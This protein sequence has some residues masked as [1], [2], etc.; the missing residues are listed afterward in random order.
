VWH[1]LANLVCQV[2]VT[3]VNCI[4]QAFIWV[5][6]WVCLA[7]VW[8][9]KWVCMFYY[10]VFWLICINGKGGSAFL[11]TDG[12][13]LMNEC[14]SGQGTTTWWRLAPDAYGRYQNGIWIRVGSSINARKNFAS[15]VLADGRLF[16]AGGEYSDASNHYV[17]DW[18][19][20][21]EIFDP[22]TN[23]WSAV[24]PPPGLGLEI[25]DAPCC[26]LPDGHLLLAIHNSPLTF[27]L[28]PL[29]MQWTMTVNMKAVTPTG[30]SW[31]LMPDRTV[32]APQCL[33]PP[34]AE[35]F[36]S[37]TGF[38]ISAGN[39]PANIVETSSATIGPGI[40]LNDGRAFFIGATAGRTALYSPGSGTWASGPTIPQTSGGMAQGSK[41]GPAAIEPIGKVL[42]PVAPVDGQQSHYLKPCSFFEFN[43]AT[44]TLSSVTNP[45]N[46][47]CET[48]VGR[49][50]LLPTGE[51][52]WA[53]EDHTH[54][55]LYRS[56]EELQASTLRP[57]VTASPPTAPPGATIS[58]SGTNFN[59]FSNGCAYG[60]D[61]TPAT[62]YPIVRIHNLQ[63]GKFTYCRTANHKIGTQTSMGVSTGNAIVTTQ[64]TI[65]ANIP[66]GPSH[67]Y[68][69]A[70]GI[71]SN[72]VNITV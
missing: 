61:Y 27:K 7:A 45:P 18:T 16:V 68:V 62:N 56:S 21:C 43:P 4:C 63:N 49:L 50:L 25:G 41:D 66:T 39:L 6:K 64:V 2:F 14:D 58:V 34:H 11:L 36:D 33:N 19:A 32:V 52:F 70:N 10:W 40:L 24:P 37:G 17:Q 72:P 20:K 54:F 9:S 22:L 26:M 35:K 28:D 60:D 29:T 31:C 5:S 59:G 69:V 57:V 46:W 67:L 71:F 15:A 23:A 51:I 30:E 42:F 65:P 44:M 38:W 53:R 48:R 12:S 13:I 1:W 3:I 8:V 47:N 55:Y